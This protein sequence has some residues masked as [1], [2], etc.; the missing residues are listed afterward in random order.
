MR[1]V[2]PRIG[3]NFHTST[4]PTAKA[5]LGT[6]FYNPPD[7]SSIRM[8]TIKEMI[9]VD[10][11]PV[12]KGPLSMRYAHIPFPEIIDPPNNQGEPKKETAEQR[13]AKGPLSL[14]IFKPDTSVTRTFQ[15]DYTPSWAERPDKGPLSM[16]QF[17]PTNKTA[18]VA[19]SDTSHTNY[20]HARTIKNALEILL[21]GGLHQK[22][23]QRA[24]HTHTQHLKGCTI[25][26]S[27]N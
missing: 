14:A 2:C 11:V 20:I 9:A 12:S 22:R 10:Q 23:Q 24:A 17:N 13:N 6:A 5:P 19:A 25:H 4:T 26:K 1:Q 16:R 15:T 21:Q 7:T 3:T 27:Q 18:T 8:G